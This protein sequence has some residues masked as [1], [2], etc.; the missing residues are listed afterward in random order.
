MPGL[1]SRKEQVTAIRLAR[2]QP[3]SA[4]ELL[5]VAETLKAR[6]VDAAMRDGRVR[7][8]LG[9]ARHR[10]LAVDYREEKSD[11][12][13]LIRLGDV[14]FYDY[15]RDVLVVASVEARSGRVVD[16]VERQ[17]SSPPITD[18]ER[19]E[20]IDIATRHGHDGPSLRRKRSGTVAFP[21]P[22]YAFDRDMARKGH[23]GCSLFFRDGPDRIGAIT[24]DLSA[25]DVFPDELLP[26]MLRS[27]P[28]RGP[29]PPEGVS[30]AR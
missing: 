16:L 3:E 15:D 26:D 18:D 12:G 4:A 7:A 9:E 10:V 6:A 2:S 8:R 14:C 22:S 30:D 25:Q 13:R 29:R 27:R 1:A 19:A 24:V 20:A 21:S 28:S 17:G 5:I 11:G 23:R